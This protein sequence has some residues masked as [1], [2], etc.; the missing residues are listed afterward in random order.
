MRGDIADATVEVLAKQTYEPFAEAEQPFV[1]T[2][3]STRDI[4][5][6]IQSALA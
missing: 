6:Q 5:P 4:Q 1:V 3:D 2:V